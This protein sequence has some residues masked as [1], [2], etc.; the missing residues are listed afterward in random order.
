[1]NY[2][3]PS[4]NKTS[5]QYVECILLPKVKISSAYVYMVNNNN[6]VQGAC[7]TACAAMALSPV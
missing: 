5:L 2:S 3:E 7:M 6:I 4:N 1:M